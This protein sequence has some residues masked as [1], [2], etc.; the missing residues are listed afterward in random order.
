MDWMTHTVMSHS[1]YI[2]ADQA[3]SNAAQA[4]ICPRRLGGEG[5]VGGDLPRDMSWNPEPS[6]PHSSWLS[7]HMCPRTMPSSLM[8][9]LF[10]TDGNITSQDKE[11]CR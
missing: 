1:S 10:E 11:S 8:W 3:H 4:Q 2:R 9:L 5:G 6:W 7:S